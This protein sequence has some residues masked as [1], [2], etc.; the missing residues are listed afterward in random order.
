MEQANRFMQ[1]LRAEDVGREGGTE[2]LYWLSER[3]G[4]RAGNVQV[5]DIKYCGQYYLVGARLR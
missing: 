5:P 3:N 2:T 4:G 1:I